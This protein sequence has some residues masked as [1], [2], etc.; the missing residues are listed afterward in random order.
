V[1]PKPVTRKF[2]AYTL[3]GHGSNNGV[4]NYV[5][6]ME[7]L[8][9]IPAAARQ[10]RTGDEVLAVAQVFEEAGVWFLRCVRGREGDLPLYYDLTTGQEREGDVGKNEVLA[11][12]ALFAFDPATRFVVAEQRRPGVGA[13]ELARALSRI[14]RE[15]GF[16]GRL[17]ITLTPVVR[18]E[19]F[20]A[21]LAEYARI[22]AVSVVVTRPNYDWDDHA[23][24][25]TELAAESNAGKAELTMSASRGQSLE[26]E[27]GII[28]QVRELLADARTPVQDVKLTGRRRNSRQDTSVRLGKHTESEEVQLPRVGATANR[29]GFLR[30]GAR[31]FLDRLRD[32]YG[33]DV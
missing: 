24:E 6:F 25:L 4:I 21:E 11:G 13:G 19:D 7:A 15:A 14:G 26:R 12:A 17:T 28:Q 3:H 27:A 16:D 31:A 9:S 30:L 5:G 10:A 1:A 8:R 29:E 32:R 23:V 20:E 22:K 2:R 18:S 33:L